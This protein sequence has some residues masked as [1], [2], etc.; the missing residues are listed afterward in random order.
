[1]ALA[2]AAVA[3]TAELSASSPG[4]CSLA[5]ASAIPFLLRKVRTKTTVKPSK[6][7]QKPI[8]NQLKSDEIR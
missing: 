8:K 7:H 6:T 5:E 2:V 1:L 4:S 3:A